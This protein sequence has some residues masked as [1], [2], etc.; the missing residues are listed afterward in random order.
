MKRLSQVSILPAHLGPPCCQ[1]CPDERSRERKQ[2]TEHPGAEHQ[3]RRVDLPRN[4]GRI[5]E[6]AR[7]NDAAH[8]DHGGVEESEPA[9]EFWLRVLCH[10]W[11]EPRIIAQPINGPPRCCSALLLRSIG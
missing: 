1:L 5:H 8:D 4:D 6:D 7:P 2:T 11:L 10:P 3:K 9:R